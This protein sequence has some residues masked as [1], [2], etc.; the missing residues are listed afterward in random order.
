MALPADEI[1]LT[2]K[3]E[4]IVSAF[5]AQYPDASRSTAVKFCF[6]RKFELERIFPLYEAYKKRVQER[7][8][9][10]VTIVDVL[11]ELRTEKMY[12]PGSRDRQGAALFVV[13]A[14]SHVPGQFPKES[15]LRLA[16]YMGERV[17]ESLK[18]QKNGVT[19]LI[20]L[21]GTEWASFDANFMA[22]II[23]FFQNHIPAAVKNILIWR[24]PWWIKSAIR[25]VSPFLKEKMRQ[26]IHLC[27]N[28]HALQEYIDEQQLPSAFGGSLE[29]D[30]DSFIRR[31]LSKTSGDDVLMALV[32]DAKGLTTH[33]R[34]LDMHP[35][36]VRMVREDD[37]EA[38]QTER[39]AIIAVLDEEIDRAIA[40]RRE[41]ETVPGYPM[42][43]YDIMHRRRLR[44][45]LDV[46]ANYRHLETV[47]TPDALHVT[48]RAIQ[49]IPNESERI[50]RMREAILSDQAA[51]LRHEVAK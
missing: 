27:D 21:D 20:D 9:E 17:T 5:M 22:E 48:W 51:F 16:F 14:G 33:V 43:V 2:P 38:L 41:Q 36:S 39:E 12:L 50:S 23:D 45:T 1:T 47:E 34:E 44:L 3:Q 13:R 49:H 25:V 30:H 8:L 37:E 29:Y 7:H 46:A 6:G 11:D 24:A 40:C 19:L 4:A 42:P 26:R 18:T 35:G 28:L 15:T 32:E 10:N 31:E